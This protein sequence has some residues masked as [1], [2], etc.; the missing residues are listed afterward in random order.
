M[1]A[2]LT[3]WL[4]SASAF[5]VSMAGTPGPNNAMVAA[6]GANFG[7][8]RTV[9]HLLGV[10]IGF[11]VMLI[12]VALGAGGVLRAVPVLQLV[13]KWVGVVYLLYL[14]FKIASAQPAAP[15]A[16]SSQASGR[17]LTF[18]QA[19]LFQWINPKA[20]IIALGA[21]AAYTT[22]AGGIVLV[23]VVAI[24]V[25]FLI[26]TLPCL[27]FWTMTGVGAARLL[28]TRRQMRVFNIVMAALLAASL[29]PLI[30]EI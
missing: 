24:A 3:A 9:P 29:V 22:A 5:A 18:L 26:A 28:R 19:A 8:A 11:P 12:A 30:E 14:A 4:F 25:I 23:Q 1:G 17:P 13:M 6:S 21:I 27:A 7:F 15:D 16:A 20:W 2:D 10:A